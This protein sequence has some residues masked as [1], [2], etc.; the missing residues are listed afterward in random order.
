MVT[1]PKN[2][3]ISTIVFHSS[4]SSIKI[5]RCP[6]EIEYSPEVAQKVLDKVIAWMNEHSSAHSGER[7]HKKNANC[8]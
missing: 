6:Y 2:L 7:I 1:N 5:G 3:F 8:P 4:P